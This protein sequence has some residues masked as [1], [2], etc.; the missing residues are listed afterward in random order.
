M[1]SRPGQ[2]LQLALCD[3][4]R[5]T[6]ANS[7]QK[8]QPH[9]YT[10]QLTCVHIAEVL[11]RLL[12]VQ[13]Q[14]LAAFRQDGPMHSASAAGCTNA[15]GLHLRPLH[16]LAPAIQILPLLPSARHGCRRLPAVRQVVERT[17]AAGFGGSNS[18]GSNSSSGQQRRGKSGGASR[19]KSGRKKSHRIEDALSTTARKAAENNLREDE[20]KAAH[21]G[22]SQRLRGGPASTAASVFGGD[23]DAECELLLNKLQVMRKIAQIASAI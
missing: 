14:L 22:S 19:A 12:S 16:A 13:Q 10:Q 20:I 18:S 8:P 23:T 15:D 2:V 5:F 17:A 3:C 1:L 6:C 21:P 7:N 11:T 9:C 4:M